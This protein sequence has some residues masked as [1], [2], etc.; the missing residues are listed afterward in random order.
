M[1]FESED[2]AVALANGSDYGLAAS[3][4]TRDR[5]R[6]EALARRISAGTV[7][8]NDALSCYGI[9]EAPDGG[10]RSSGIGRTHGRSGLEEMVR[11]KYVSSDM[12]PRLKRVWWYPYGANFARQ[13]EALLD[14]QFSTHAK[15]KLQGAFRSMS[16]L[17][18]K[19]L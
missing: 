6:G 7:Q 16:C 19:R 1:P 10:L 13:M 3:I 8:V 5:R 17:F 15:P 14:L 11:L 4:W 9:S 18:G 12:L 2:Q